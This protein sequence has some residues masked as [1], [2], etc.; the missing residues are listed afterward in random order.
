M[1]SLTRQALQC[2]KS[3]VSRCQQKAEEEE[4]DDNEAKAA[5]PLVHVHN[6]LQTSQLRARK[7]ESLVNSRSVQF[8]LTHA[9][10]RGVE[11]MD[12]GHTFHP[13]KHLHRAG[14][15]V[16]LVQRYNSS[17]QPAGSGTGFLASL[18]GHRFLMTNHHVLSDALTAKNARARFDFIDKSEVSTGA[19]FGDGEL[20]LDPHSLF[21]TSPSAELDYAVVAYHE[22]SPLSMGR[23]P[24]SYDLSQHDTYREDTEVQ[25][26]QHPQGRPMEMSVGQVK[27]QVATNFVLYDASTDYGSS[28]GLVIGRLHLPLALHHQRVPDIAMNRGV[29][30]SA[31]V[32]DLRLKLAARPKTV[33][34][35]ELPEELAGLAHH[36][37]E[38]VEMDQ[39][40]KRVVA[41][42]SSIG[43]SSKTLKVVSIERLG[44]FR[45][46][47]S[48]DAECRSLRKQAQ[49]NKPLPSWIPSSVPSMDAW[50]FS[51]SVAVKNMS[52]FR[53]TPK[54][55]YFAANHTDI[56]IECRGTGVPTF[57][58]SGCGKGRELCHKCE[59][60][61]GGECVPGSYCH[62]TGYNC[63]TEY[64]SKYDKQFDWNSTAYDNKPY[65]IYC[66]RS[67][68]W[69]DSKRPDHDHFFPSASV[70]PVCKACCGSPSVVS[71]VMLDVRLSAS[72]D[73]INVISPVSSL[74]TSLTDAVGCLQGQSLGNT[75][76]DVAIDISD[77]LAF[78]EISPGIAD[79]IMQHILAHRPRDNLCRLRWQKMELTFIPIYV[80][81]YSLGTARG[82]QLVCFANGQQAPI[83]TESSKEPN[84]SAANG[85][86]TERS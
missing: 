4:E 18:D 59:G 17:F 42:L 8:A 24:F 50:S 13:L 27:K 83:L 52:L 9:E 16:C 62:G 58:C 3:I 76:E 64:R 47:V 39:A 29:L 19:R 28:G 32:T 33:A 75:V 82:E 35:S 22:A 46:Q 65:A 20:S 56:C 30:M 70:I 11:E 53:T 73:V 84:K 78:E 41:Y 69:D 71:R 80:V 15:V 85:G 5:V 79:L 67:S 81:K 86:A 38:L 68:C 23:H 7:R 57:S 40:K 74:S 61:K 31:I 60:R 12:T 72:R 45:A 34:A 66:G 6:R 48:N 1:W 21:L 55:T 44:C 43:E 2:C 14:K 77:M 49:G 26:F 51:A 37:T 36:F 25:V 63:V 10:S 54:Q